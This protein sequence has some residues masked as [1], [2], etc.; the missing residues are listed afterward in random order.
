MCF[1][2]FNTVYDIRYMTVKSVKLGFLI[3]QF[4]LVD[5]S[6]SVASESFPNKRSAAATT[7]LAFSCSMANSF[8]YL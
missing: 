7:L 5:E 2:V 6:E 4:I 1:T 8:W 3:D